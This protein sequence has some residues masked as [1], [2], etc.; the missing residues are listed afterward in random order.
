MTDPHLVSKIETATTEAELDAIRD[1]FKAR[2]EEMPSDGVKALA[3]RRV[4]LARK[5][6][7]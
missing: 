1:A 6:Y 3:L 7:L 5:D 2:G 4:E